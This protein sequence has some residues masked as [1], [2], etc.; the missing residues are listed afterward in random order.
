[1]EIL[2]TSDEAVSIADV[3][4]EFANGADGVWQ[5]RWSGEAGALLGPG[6]RLLV[7]DR[8]W[9]GTTE[10]T[11]EVA[12]G[13]QNGPD[14]I[15][16]V[17]GSEVLDLLG[18]GHGLDLHLT[19]TAA[20]TVRPGLALARRPDGY[21]TGN[22]R[23]DFRA[24]TPTPGKVNFSQWSLAVKSFLCEPPSL[25]SAHRPVLATVELR[26]SGWAD[27]PAGSIQCLV[28]GGL[29]EAAWPGCQA[30]SS[31]TVEWLVTP[32]TAGV[33]E[34]S[35]AVTA[36]GAA[37]DWSAVAGRCQVGPGHLVVQEVMAAPADTQGEWIEVQ[38]LRALDLDT[39]SLRDADGDWRRLPSLSM[40]GGDRLVLAQDAAALLMREERASAGQSCRL[41]TAQVLELSGWPSLNNSAPADRQWADRVMLADSV[42]TVVD[43]VTLGG[44]VY[45]V[46]AGRSW[47]RAAVGPAD[48]SGWNWAVSRALAGGT[49]GCPNS[50]LIPTSGISGSL[51]PV[52]R[53]LDPA[54]GVAVIHVRASVPPSAGRWR[55]EIYDLWGAAV[56][57]WSGDDLGGGIRDLPWSGEDDRGRALPAG[58][59]VVLLVTSDEAGRTLDRQRVL[60]VVR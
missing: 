36:D 19:E 21:D 48:P 25:P 49:P 37:P 11:H 7:V 28:D 56:R 17:R 47:E 58:G 59:Y 52:P 60:V 38:A 26:N 50:I 34:V 12:L 30:D 9:T 15:R 51:D 29:Y 24:T 18:Y 13:L 20:A 41:Q 33:H 10:S 1:V 55:V 53:V 57:T 42:G 32:T 22:N 40:A 54:A 5:L 31:R 35:L 46:P 6:E 14:A 3:S 4:L 43:H 39:Y 16:L 23:N 2:N 27:W 8:G 44:D 45:G